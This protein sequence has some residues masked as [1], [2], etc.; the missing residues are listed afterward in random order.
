MKIDLSIFKSFVVP[1]L[2]IITIILIIPFAFI[3]LLNNVRETNDSL[4]SD[5]ERLK[6]LSDKLDTLNSLDEAE[7]NE[8][9]A[10]AEQ[11]L[12]VGKDLAPL[13]VGVQNLAAGS[14]LLVE[15]IS[16][17]PGIVATESAGT[18]DSTTNQSNPQATPNSQ[19]DT[20]S[21]ALSL[22]LKLKGNLI[23]L[24][25]FL[26]KLQVSKRLSFANIVNFERGDDESTITVEL[27]TPFRPVHQSDEDIAAAPLQLLTSVHEATLDIIEAYTN[28][29][30]IQ[31]NEVKT[32][33]IKDPFKG[34]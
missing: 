16:L 30:N 32:N 29:T 10:I 18:K 34:E 11:G 13:I 3:P 7:I 28:I 15:G 19:I 5:S 24:I 1:A 12:P 25:L 6:N 17:S 4:K 23:D 14:N 26:S 22:Q 20:N 9:L 27:S 31:I 8:K 21:D 33:V 2:I